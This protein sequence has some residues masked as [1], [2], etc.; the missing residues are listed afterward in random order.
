M[1]ARMAQR[2]QQIEP[3]YV[4]KILQQARELESQGKSIIHMEIGEP[5]FA[6]PETVI[7]AGKQALDKQ[8]T[9]YTPA[10]GL[11]ELRA[12][13]AHQYSGQAAI[14]PQRIV[15]TPGASGALQLV[16]AMLLDPADGIMMAD[17]G[18][19]C[20]RHIASLYNADV[21]SVAV[22][23]E[24]DYQLSAELVESHWRE[25]TRVVLIASPSN[26]T[27]TLMPQ[28]QLSAIYQLV[29]EKDASLVVDE[30]YHGL[31]YDKQEASALACGDQLFVINSFSK[32]YGMTG[33]RVGWLVMPDEYIE[34]ANRLAQNMFIAAPTISQ[35]AALAA[36]ASETRPELI[37]RRDI[38]H[39]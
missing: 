24:T 5:D 29:R 9:R 25:N 14:D 1:T 6:S 32:F 33:W 36:L 22:N 4:M 8:L 17:P 26:P 13:I 31:V 11:P 3:F 12:D 27:G 15:V 18:Y 7:R 20:N 21:Q 34:V 39:Q 23:E 35:Y 30:I 28:Q 37:R 16:M 19:P 38:F 2:A 10:N